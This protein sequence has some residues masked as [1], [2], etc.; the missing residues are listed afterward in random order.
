MKHIYILVALIMVALIPQELGAIEM[1]KGLKIQDVFRKY[2]K[3]KNVTMVEMSKEM[4]DAYNISFYRSITIKQDSKALSFVR[5]CLR[6][7]QK[8]ARK[9]KETTSGGQLTSAYYELPGK[10]PEENRFILFKVNKKGVI[11]L[12]YIEGELDSEDL[13]TLLFEK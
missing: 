8:D 11:T 12:V 7:D 9:I 6:A 3:Q 4:L 10:K 13:I 5:E 2:G 1:Q